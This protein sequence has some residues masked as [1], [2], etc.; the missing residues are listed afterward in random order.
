MAHQPSESQSESA[1]SSETQE[2]GVVPLRVA[3]VQ[4]GRPES[5][6]RRYG[7]ILSEEAVDRP[8]MAVSEVD[9]GMFERGSSP[10][11]SRRELLDAADVVYLQWNR[12]SWGKGLRSVVRF[13][14]FRRSCRRPL[15]I[16]LHDVFPREGVRARW[17][18]TDALALRIVGRNA[19]RVVVHSRTEVARL[20]GL[21]PMRKVRVVPHFVEERQIPMTAA[22][23][24]RRLGVEG[25]KVVTLLGFIYGR[26]GHKILVEA[27]PDLAPD[28]LVVYAGGPVA[29]REFATRFVEK[30]RTELGIEDR[31]RITGWLSEEDL[32]T[33]VA[34]TDLAVLPFKE[35][36]ASGSLSSWIAAG[37]PILASDLPGFREYD[38][39]VP[40]ALRLFGPVE[41][42][43]LARAISEQ[44]AT[45]LPGTDPNVVALR[46]DL[47]VPKTVGRYL[48]VYREAAAEAAT[49]GSGQAR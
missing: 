49:G 1:P 34:A 6:V 15:V 31:L 43:P 44:L 21:I 29:E 9:L 38:V 2:T 37:K 41:P 3:F 33:W 47:T 40:G 12:R 25:R 46:D 7:R 4:I 16:T 22:D 39:M 36:S 5:G 14:A 45:D 17:L 24:R 20:K 30:R 18:T 13:L 32:E 35:L 19:S 27:I 26:K 28:V 11:C 10:G 48:A 23:A 42:K 8:D